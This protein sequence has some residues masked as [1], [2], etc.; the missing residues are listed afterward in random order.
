LHLV[1]VQLLSYL[2]GSIELQ[3]EAYGV[4]F[5]IRDV[6]LSMR[7]LSYTFRL[8]DSSYITYLDLVTFP[9][10]NLGLGPPM[11]Y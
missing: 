8:I 1:N 5:S 11:L 10:M 6:V 4:R 2:E 9:T 7:N 3:I